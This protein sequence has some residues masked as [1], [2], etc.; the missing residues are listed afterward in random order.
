VLVGVDDIEGTTLRVDTDVA[1]R[2]GSTVTLILEVGVYAV[3]IGPL[4]ASG[5]SSQNVA[6]LRQEHGQILVRVVSGDGDLVQLSPAGEAARA[7]TSD[8]MGMARIAEADR[9]CLAILMDGS[10]S[11]RAIPMRVIRRVVELLAGVAAV[12][13]DGPVS[14]TVSGSTVTPE[15]VDDLADLPEAASAMLERSPR[16]SGARL[17]TTG[18][19]ARGLHARA[20]T[21]VLT[22]DVPGDLDRLAEVAASADMAINVVLLGHASLAPPAQLAGLPLTFLDSDVLSLEDVEPRKLHLADTVSA[23]LRGA[24]PLGVP[25]DRKVSE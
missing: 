1:F 15:S 9:L 7:A 20:L 24:I 5:L 8:L 16:S 19:S 25:V 18:A 10:A 17:S 3:E 23:L 12:T 6:F 21:W 2:A 13:A 11:F 22:D 14:L 4:H